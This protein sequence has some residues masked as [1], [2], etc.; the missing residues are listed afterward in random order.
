ME[1]YYIYI[2]IYVYMYIYTYSS[3][4]TCMNRVSASQ[5]CTAGGGT[6]WLDIVVV[7]DNA[8]ISQSVD[9]WSWDLL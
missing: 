7:Q 1:G 3:L 6:D 8:V 5:Q 4:L 2:Y 9:V